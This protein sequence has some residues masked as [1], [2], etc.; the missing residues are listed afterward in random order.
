MEGGQR[1]VSQLAQ[2]GNNLGFKQSIHKNHHHE[3]HHHHH[4]HHTLIGRARKCQLCQLFCCASLFPFT[5][6][7][8]SINSTFHFTVILMIEF[9]WFSSLNFHVT[10][11]YV[12]SKTPSQDQMWS[13]GLDQ[14]MWL[15]LKS[16]SLSSP[17]NVKC[18]KGGCSGFFLQ[19]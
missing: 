16:K 12:V 6:L 14:L 9:A 13:A 11:Y 4:L 15:L 8:I 18:V 3:L 19:V 10:A 7:I 5:H 2:K 17:G 1:P